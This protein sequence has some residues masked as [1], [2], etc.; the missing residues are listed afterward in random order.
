M[1]PGGPRSSVQGGSWGWG[2]RPCGWTSC[3][4]RVALTGR[5]GGEGSG[6]STAQDEQPSLSV[7]VCVRGCVGSWGGGR[8]G[9]LVAGFGRLP[10]LPPLP[11]S[12]GPL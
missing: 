3:S 6:G 7:S 2:G 5:V 10:P 8:A 12:I 4:E 11:I 1:G 9:R